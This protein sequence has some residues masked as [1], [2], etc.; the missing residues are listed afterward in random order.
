MVVTNGVERA[1]QYCHE[2]KSD[3]LD[4]R[5]RVRIQSAMVAFSGEHEY[6]G[7]Q[8]ERGVV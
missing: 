1:I 6:G 3:Y 8:G 7:R 4:R 5:A 2:I